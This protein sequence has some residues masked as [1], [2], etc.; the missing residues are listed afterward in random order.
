MSYLTVTRKC[1]IFLSRAAKMSYFFIKSGRAAPCGRRYKLKETAVSV[2]VYYARIV[3]GT[4]LALL[5]D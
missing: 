4:L 3:T 1:R 2:T 5:P